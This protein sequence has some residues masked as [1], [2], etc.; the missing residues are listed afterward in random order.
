MVKSKGDEMV[1][2]VACMHALKRNA[3]RILQESQK[4]KLKNP[5]VG[6]RIM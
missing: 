3:Y 6:E 4:R 1:C 5:E 2:H